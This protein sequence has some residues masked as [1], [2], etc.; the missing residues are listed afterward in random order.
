MQQKNSVKNA[1][2]LF[3][4]NYANFSGRTSLFNYWVPMLINYAF[5]AGFSLL[6]MMTLV[7]TSV[8]VVNTQAGEAVFSTL[9]RAGVQWGV[10][11]AG[12]VATLVAAAVG[13]YSIII[14][15]PGLAATARRLHDAGFSAAFILVLLI[16]FGGLILFILLLCSSKP[17]NQYGCPGEEESA[18]PPQD[19]MRQR[20]YP[21]EGDARSGRGH[22]FS[23][24]Q[25]GNRQDTRYVYSDPR[26]LTKPTV[27]E[28]VEDRG[29]R[30][31]DPP[32]E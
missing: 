22:E 19:G 21:P 1:M 28:P 25:Q 10:R 9:P 27:Q 26:H 30:F 5:I 17:A 24:A 6:L 31:G 18:Y 23:R 29:R 11:A 7:S 16:P 13:V 14:I 32:L 3:F 12:L 20:A 8:S 2:R 15:I 4:K